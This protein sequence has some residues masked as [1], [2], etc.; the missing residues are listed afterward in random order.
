MVMTC[1]RSRAPRRSEVG[2]TPR[3]GRRPRAEDCDKL[4]AAG[5]RL[6]VGP[7]AQSYQLPDGTLLELRWRAVRGGIGG[8]GVALSLGCPGCLSTVRV[9]RRPPGEGWSC[10]RCRPVSHRSHRRSGGA[11]GQRKPTTW[12]V[13]Q[14]LSEQRRVVALLGLA[15]WPPSPLFWS[16]TDVQALPRVPDA[17]R[18]SQHRRA[19]LELRLDALESLRIAA[20][21]PGLAWGLR[22]LGSKQK[23]D[24]QELDWVVCAERVLK[25]TAWAMRRQ[26]HDPRTLRLREAHRPEPFDR[27]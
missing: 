17:P 21:L 7:T 19:A 27:A 2:A 1:R 10:W 22:L 25:G 9:L 16:L 15:Q 20:Q 3:Q 24:P 23:L 4:T 13:D 8:R 11:R 5:L 14:I 12:H 18:L 26:A 6:L